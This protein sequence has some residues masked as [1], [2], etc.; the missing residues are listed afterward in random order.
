[1]K[2]QNSNDSIV[3]CGRRWTMS[4][5][6]RRNEERAFIEAFE[7]QAVAKLGF[8]ETRYSVVRQW[9]EINDA[10]KIELKA[11]LRGYRNGDYVVVLNHDVYDPSLSDDEKVA[12]VFELLGIV[13]KSEFEKTVEMMISAGLI[14]SDYKLEA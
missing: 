7:P 4:E 3:R 2:L 11:H 8:V 12:K 14:D 9:L 10:T 5:D 13:E 1:M 6:A